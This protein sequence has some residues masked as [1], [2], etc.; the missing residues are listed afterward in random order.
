MAAMLAMP[1]VTESLLKQDIYL[2]GCDNN[3]PCQFPLMA[4]QPLKQ[5]GKTMSI[6]T[7]SPFSYPTPLLGYKGG[8]RPCCTVAT[9]FTGGPGLATGDQPGQPPSST[10]DPG[11]TTAM[12][13]GPEERWS[14]IGPALQ[15]KPGRWS[16][17]WNEA[18]MPK[19]TWRVIL[20]Y[21]HKLVGQP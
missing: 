12:T 5:V 2:P 10:V 8:N 21:T 17:P 3:K 16:P 13:A 1:A 9:D 20:H 18:H 11:A 7:A 15:N 14:S 19:K 4:G 6:S